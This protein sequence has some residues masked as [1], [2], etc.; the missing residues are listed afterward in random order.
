M[1][2]QR[3]ELIVTS[4]KELELTDKIA[5]DLY[6][7]GYNA[8][9][10]VIVTVSTDYSSI[11]GQLLR[12][13]LSFD[14]E[15]CNGFGV[16]VPYPNEDWN[17]NYVNAVMSMFKLHAE[18][19]QFKNIILVEAGVIRGGNYTMIVDIIK[20]Y[21]TLTETIVTVA[22]FENVNSRFKSDFVGEF[23]DNNTQDLTFWW[24]EYNNHWN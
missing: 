21:L 24:E 22:M 11:I 10:S 23:Y 14:G 15:M 16:D 18:D 6:N 1:V 20:R 7:A 19:V 2:D 17:E 8:S 13:K 12:H 3:K 4:A 5:K 9:N